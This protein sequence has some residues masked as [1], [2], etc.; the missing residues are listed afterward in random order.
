MKERFAS[1]LVAY[2]RII[3][4]IFIVLALACSA[5]IPFVN[6]N[7]DMT[8]YLPADSDMRRGLDLMEAEFGREDAS[9]LMVMFDDLSTNAQ[10]LAIREELAAL[11]DQ[12]LPEATLT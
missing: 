7:K 11:P 3:L 12:S 8:K 1:F 9:T 6:I 4:I 10:R 2:N 5:L